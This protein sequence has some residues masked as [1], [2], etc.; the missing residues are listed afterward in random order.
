MQ[1]QVR[2]LRWALCSN[3]TLGW[4]PSCLWIPFVIECQQHVF[5]RP[6]L[7]E[8]RYDG[9]VKRF[10]PCRAELSIPTFSA[11][12]ILQGSDGAQ[13]ATLCSGVHPVAISG[14]TNGT[15]CSL[16]LRAASRRA[17]REATAT[18]G[19]MTHG[20]AALCDS[21]SIAELP[22]SQTWWL[23]ACTSR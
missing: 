16:H 8:M 10:Y 14:Y 1:A 9:I 18:W 7:I 23:P 6:L 11:R 5:A 20:T 22:A 2:A 4:V 19:R 12:Q 15:D 3:S 13:L 17:V 21:A